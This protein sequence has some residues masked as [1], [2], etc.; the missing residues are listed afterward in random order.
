MKWAEIS[1]S[2][3]KYL[4]G[5]L[6]CCFILL[7]NSFVSVD[8]SGYELPTYRNQYV[9][10]VFSRFVPFSGTGHRLGGNEL[11][12]ETEVDNGVELAQSAGLNKGRIG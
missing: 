6:C 9:K 2:K 8:K 12:G 3:A 1:D 7:S 5:K 10:S 4:E 11:N